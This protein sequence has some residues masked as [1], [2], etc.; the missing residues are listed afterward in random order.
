MS[1]YKVSVE[2]VWPRKDG[3]GCILTGRDAEEKLHRFIADSIKPLPRPGEVWRLSGELVEN[4]DYGLQCRVAEATW[5]EPS[6][7]LLIQFLCKHPAFDGLGIGTT[8]AAALWAHFGTNLYA[9][10]DNGDQESLAQVEKLPRETIPRLV[11]AWRTIAEEGKVVRWLATH[12]FPPS[13][14]QKLLSFYGP[15]TV[16]KLEDNPYRLLAFCSFAQCEAAAGRMQISP[17]DPRR[18]VAVVQHCLYGD[19]EHGNTRTSRGTL[20]RLMRKHLPGTV[21]PEAVVETVKAVGLIYADSEWVSPIGIRMMELDALRRFEDLLTVS[22]EQAE[23]FPGFIRDSVAQAVHAF[24]RDAGFP[25]NEEQRR[26]VEMAVVEPLSVLCGGAGVGKTTILMALCKALP[27]SIYL[28]AVTGQASRRMAEATGH[29]ATTVERFIRTVATQIPS[30]ESPLL[31]IDEASMLDLALTTRLLRVKPLKARMLLVGDPAQLPP[32]SFGLIFHELATSSRVPR[33]ELTIINRQKE[34]TGIPRVSRLIR[35]GTVPVLPNRHGPGG[36]SFIPL[37]RRNVI[38]QVLDLKA[39]MPEAQVL[40]CKN[41]GGLGV[42]DVNQVFAN[43][44]S[45]GRERCPELDMSVG[46]PVIFKK[47]IGSLNLVNGSLGVISAVGRN[48]AGQPVISC[49]FDG[50][51]KDL[52]GVALEHLRL[53]YAITAHSAQGSQFERVIVVIEQSRVLDR[54]LIYTALTRA[55]RQ[56]VFVGDQEAFEAAIKSPP[57][58]A[59]RQVWFRLAAEQQRPAQNAG[60]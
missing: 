58:A 31:V 21:T 23:L 24:E 19:M 41:Y 55:V 2:R 49:N 48:E 5:E 26:A 43:I 52:E 33:T 59:T 56:T 17:D 44:R 14:A 60:I 57:K 13:L 38:Q 29:V 46:D 40:C 42:E 20:S 6:G 8:R 18:L 51:I 36:V 28:M 39:E 45:V 53:A 32:V 16:S 50:E 30:D 47:N 15:E 37:P 4:Q 1:A 22:D 12:D 9:V 34:E 3:K 25:L 54:T 7:K 27:H 35:F 11:E 10:L